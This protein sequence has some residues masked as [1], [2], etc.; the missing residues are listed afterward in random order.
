MIAASVVIPTRNRKLFLSEAI[1]TVVEQTFLDWELIVVDDGSTDDTQEFLRTLHDP[2]IRSIR[3]E[4]QGGPSIAR[5]AG[6]AEA[7]GELIMFLDDDDL[8]RP[9]TLARLVSALRSHSDAVAAVGACRLFRE[10]GDSI[11][12][13]HP[14]RAYTGT[15]WREFLFGWWSNSGQNLYRIASIKGIGGFDPALPR[16][17][18]RKLWLDVAWRGRVCVLPFVAMEYRQHAGQRTEGPDIAPT[19]QRIWDEFI[20]GLPPSYQGQARAIRRAAELV[21][22]SR[23]ARAARTFGAALRM[24]LQACLMAP[25]LLASPLT[26][27]PL[28][29]DIKKCLLRVSAP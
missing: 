27:R 29:W 10:N 22:R 17:Q 3:R 5:N 1:T 6:L 25:L 8:L 9:Y 12:V 26:G 20:A 2:R 23:N 24:Q 21:T 11:K 7:R 19:R 13:Y 16:A 28:W 14:A 18:D 4:N 15:I